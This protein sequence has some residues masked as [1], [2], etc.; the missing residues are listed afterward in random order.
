MGKS[1]IVLLMM[2]LTAC[3]TV[4]TSVS[5][6][7]D[8]VV[9]QSETAAKQQKTNALGGLSPEDALEYMKETDNLVI[10]DVATTD[11]YNTEHFKG[12]IHIPI[13][14]LDSEAED[15][16]YKEIPADRPVLLHC[17]LGMIVPGAYKRVLELRQDIP[18]IAYIDGAPLFEEYNEWIA[19]Q[20][21]HPQEQKLLGG[22]SPEEK[23]EHNKVEQ[24]GNL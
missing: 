21:E 1:L 13:E 23:M 19:E 24:G 22:Q 17:R 5:S 8:I 16:L 12:A 4:N 11:R 10:V 2:A 6:E 7:M 14:E 3:G 20:Q 9:P 18:E 15:A